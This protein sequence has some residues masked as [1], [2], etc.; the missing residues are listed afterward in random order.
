MPGP[1]W[2]SSVQENYNKLKVESR[3]SLKELGK[4]KEELMKRD[5]ELTKKASELTKT[6]SKLQEREG[7]I[8]GYAIK[9]RL[10]W[11]F[12]AAEPVSPRSPRVTPSG[13]PHDEV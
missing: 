9:K 5:R 12:G 6:Q 4:T 2:Q 3:D 11:P 1:E 7:D 8:V 10:P 13:S